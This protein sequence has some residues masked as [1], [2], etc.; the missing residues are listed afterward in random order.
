M[1]AFDSLAFATI[2]AAVASV[3]LGIQAAY[4]AVR[5]ARVRRPNSTRR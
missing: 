4:V 1:G 3:A 5:R 2:V